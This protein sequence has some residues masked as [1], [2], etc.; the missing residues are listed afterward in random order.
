VSFDP[1]CIV[2]EFCAHGSMDGWIVKHR[3]QLEQACACVCVCVCDNAQYFVYS[4][5]IVFAIDVAAALQHLHEH[6]II[7]RDLATRNLLLTADNVIRVADFGL[8][9]DTGRDGYVT[10][11][12]LGCVNVIACCACACG[13]D[14][15]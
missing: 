3:P 14:M 15:L 9:R 5:I 2:T 7:H 10:K 13:H 8:A 11:T 4:Q 6:H 1:L 12:G